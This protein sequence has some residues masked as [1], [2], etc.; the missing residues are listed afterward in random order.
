MNAAK[1]MAKDTDGEVL[2][3][4]EKMLKMAKKNKMKMSVV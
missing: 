3:S 1:Q 4:K 2:M